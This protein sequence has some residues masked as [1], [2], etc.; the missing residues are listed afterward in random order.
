MADAPCHGR[1]L[2][3]GGD[4]H[5]THQGVDQAERTLGLVGEIFGKGGVELLFCKCGAQDVEKMVQS[6]DNVLGKHHAFVDEFSID[7]RSSEQVFKESI[8]ASL[9]SCLAQAIAPATEGL[10]LDLY[11]GTDFSVALEIACRRL[12]DHMNDA[13]A[14]GAEDEGA[15]DEGEDGDDE[16]RVEAAG[17]KRKLSGGKDEDQEDVKGG[18]GGSKG[19]D[20]RAKLSA[21]QL[22]LLKLEK[23]DYDLV[24]VT[25]SGVS[26]GLFKDFRWCRPLTEASMDVLQKT[27]LSVAGSSCDCVSSTR[28]ESRCIHPHTNQIIGS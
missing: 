2:N 13:L 15:E 27:G 28:F 12:A 22:L 18:S 25:V 3:S 26:E 11:S 7:D 19:K 1:N 23:D 8:L 6:F 14:G 17:V 4:R 10:G 16:E 5:Q 20:R 21:L 9:E 24:R